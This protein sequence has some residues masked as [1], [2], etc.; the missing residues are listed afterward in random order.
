MSDIDIVKSETQ[1]GKSALAQLLADPERLKDY[2]IETVERMFALDREIQADEARRSF[3]FAFNAV[4]SEMRVVQK[5]GRNT[6]TG[7]MF[8][9][10]EEVNGMLDPIIIKH[11]F[12]CSVS[13][14]DCPVEHHT[15]FVMI[16]R[17][18]GGHEERHRMDAPLDNVGPK[19]APTKTALHG[20]ASSYTYCERHLKLKVFNVQTTADD[21]GNAAAGLGPSSE[22]ITKDQLADLNSLIEEVKGNKEKLMKIFGVSKLSDLAVSNLKPAVTMLEA[23]RRG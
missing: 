5:T 10:A 21:D 9:R 22:K 14:E 7:S 20:L 8:A 23:K 19:G 4:Q 15:R 12:S 16:L 18:I 2:P 11:G 3:A 6:S 13:T 1:A 17:H